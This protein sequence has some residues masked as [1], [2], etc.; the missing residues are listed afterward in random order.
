MEEIKLSS[1]RMILDTN[2]EILER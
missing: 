1:D 2:E